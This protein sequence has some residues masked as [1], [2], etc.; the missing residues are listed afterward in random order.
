M[1]DTSDKTTGIRRLIRNLKK[2]FRIPEN[3]EHYSEEDLQEA[4]KKYLKFCLQNGCSIIDRTGAGD[5]GGDTQ[6]PAYPVE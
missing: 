3:L 1:A 6:D 4:E 5:N 2:E